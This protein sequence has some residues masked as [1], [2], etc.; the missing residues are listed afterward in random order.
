[1]KYITLSLVTTSFLFIGCGGGGSSNSQSTNGVAFPATSTS[2]KPTLENGKKVK[3]VVTT[4]T[5][6][7]SLLLNSINDDST[8]NITLFTQ[9]L[10]SN[11]I[12]N[13]NNNYSL[14]QVI[15]EEE[16]CSNG[17]SIVNEITSNFPQE[18]TMTQ[19]FN[20]CSEGFYQGL[21][22]VVING[23]VY[24]K[25]SNFDSQIEDY[26]TTK[27]TF[28]SDLTIKDAS[29][30]KTII[31]YKDSYFEDNT[32]EFDND[33][34]PK[35]YTVKA[36]IKASDG[37]KQYG[38]KDAFYYFTENDSEISIYQTKGRIYID[39]LT[40]YVDYDTSYNMSQIPFIFSSDFSTL[41]SGEA[42][43][44]MANNGKVK[45]IAQNN[46][47][48]TYVDADGDGIYELND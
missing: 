16:Q 12:K 28:L 41:K 6:E 5:N 11:Q 8:M 30:D 4:K 45:I 1:M 33:G 39:N 46:N 20:Q 3:E 9:N 32:L 23:K 27:V 38:E 44:N 10:F 13:L 14:N 36:T 35:K 19:T 37:L 40:S 2:A 15:R 42:R 24:Q 18:A 22:N 34:E 26:K 29:S 43:Y 31:L 47:V 21:R 25:F 7:R 17:G 48:V